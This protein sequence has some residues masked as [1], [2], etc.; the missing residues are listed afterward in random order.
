VEFLTAILILSSKTEEERLQQRMKC[1]SS[2]NIEQCDHIL[3]TG[4]IPEQ[5]V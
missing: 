2:S 4:C 1:P 3:Y 5:L